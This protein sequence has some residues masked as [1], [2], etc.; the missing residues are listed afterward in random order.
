MHFSNVYE[1]EFE[2]LSLSFI[3]DEEELIA[4]MLT[5]PMV[6]NMIGIEMCVCYDVFMAKGGTEAVVESFYS[7]MKAQS[8]AR[9]YNETLVLRTKLEWTV[10]PLIQADKFVR[11]TAKIYIEGDKKH[12]LKSHQWP[13]IGDGKSSKS[14]KVSKVIDRLSS[15]EAYLPF[16]L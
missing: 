14:Y 11:E 16:L 8:M 6:Y 3:I 15:S 7:S 2:L 1:A 5:N 12:K 13:I 10:P 4:Q 9:Q